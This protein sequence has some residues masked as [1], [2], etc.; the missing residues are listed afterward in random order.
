MACKAK[1][2]VVPSRR[3]IPATRVIPT[4]CK[5]GL[6]SMQFGSQS[7]HAFH[8]RRESKHKLT[9]FNLPMPV[10][11]QRNECC[12]WLIKATFKIFVALALCFVCIKPGFHIIASVATAATV[13]NKNV[14]RQ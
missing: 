1:L 12:D 8:N 6:I 9:C 11:A 3:V 7:M 14:Q 4:P 5:Q 10:R 13:A 2:C